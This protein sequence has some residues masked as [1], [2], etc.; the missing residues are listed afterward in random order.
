MLHS[1]SLMKKISYILFLLILI[2]VV[3]QFVMQRFS[4]EGENSVDIS[5]FQQM[6]AQKS[7][8]LSMQ[9]SESVNWVELLKSVSGKYDLEFQLKVMTPQQAEVKV[10]ETDFNLLVD[11]FAE[12]YAQG[13]RFQSIRL[14]KTDTPDMVRVDSIRLINSN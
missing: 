5:S 4:E 9:G 8:Q 6:V 1:K 10:S 7:T 13:I 2:A 3:S 12:I 14:L 11:G